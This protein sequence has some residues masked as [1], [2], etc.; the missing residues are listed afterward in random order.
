MEYETAC[1]DG[2]VAGV[3]RVSRR[4]HLLMHGTIREEQ[5]RQCDPYQSAAG[6][7]KTELHGDQP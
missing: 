1:C 3:P 2:Y 7:T 6:P 4:Y 5:S